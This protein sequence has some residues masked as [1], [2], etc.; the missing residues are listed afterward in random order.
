MQ[1]RKVA[2]TGDRT[3]NYQVMSPTHSPLSH[4]GGTIGVCQSS[5]IN[6]LPSVR[7][8]GH[9]FSPIILKLGQKVYL[10]EIA[11]EL[12]NESCRVKN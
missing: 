9:I 6:F 10:D 3:H 11:D 5:F 1:E 8:R 12:K 2:S 4:L 7:S